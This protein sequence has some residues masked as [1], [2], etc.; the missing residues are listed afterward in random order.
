[1]FCFIGLILLA[2]YCFDFGFILCILVAFVCCYS[3]RFLFGFGA[4]RCVLCG[5]LYR[6]LWNLLDCVARVLLLYFGYC[7]FV[8]VEILLCFVC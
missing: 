1:M 7:S 5:L 8:D 2:G 3:R 4:G 6:C